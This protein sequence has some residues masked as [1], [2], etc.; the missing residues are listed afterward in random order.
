[1]L[2]YF[3]ISKFAATRHHDITERI[4]FFQGVSYFPLGHQIWR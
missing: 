2:G 3:M 4:L 1:M